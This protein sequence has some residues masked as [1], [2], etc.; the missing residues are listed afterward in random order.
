MFNKFIQNYLKLRGD[1]VNF[2]EDADGVW[3]IRHNANVE[4]VQ[5]I[6]NDRDGI[7]TRGHEIPPPRTQITHRRERNNDRHG[8]ANAAKVTNMCGS[9]S[10]NTQ[11]CEILH[12]HRR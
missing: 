8:A 4:L 2:S 12:E 10:P 7:V 11:C 9:F 3:T 5:D 6:L 1:R